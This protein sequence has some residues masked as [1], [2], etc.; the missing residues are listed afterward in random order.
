MANLVNLK[1]ISLKNRRKTRGEIAFG[2]PRICHRRCGDGDEYHQ[3][4]WDCQ[5]ERLP[6]CHLFLPRIQSIVLAVFVYMLFIKRDCAAT[7]RK[8]SVKVSK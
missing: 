8:Y 1:K 2:N 5:C 4:Q 3:R 6:P 7:K